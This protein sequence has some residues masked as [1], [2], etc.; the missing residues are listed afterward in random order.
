LRK[1]PLEVPPRRKEA[2]S[3]LAT[4]ERDEERLADRKRLVTENRERF[5]HS[6]AIACYTPLVPDVGMVHG[7]V[8]LTVDVLMGRMV[9]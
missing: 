4:P 6:D 7:V 1:I 9:G 2:G 5:R 3:G 8:W